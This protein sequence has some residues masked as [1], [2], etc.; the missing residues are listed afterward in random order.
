[1]QEGREREGAKITIT[2]IFFFIRGGIY[3]GNR[4]GFR[5]EL[6]QSAAGK[7]ESRKEQAYLRT[8]GPWAVCLEPSSPSGCSCYH[9]LPLSLYLV[10]WNY[11]CFDSHSEGLQRNE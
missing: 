1:L 2:R 7:D 10:Y 8:S 9:L 5:S 11:R 6:G 3:Q 4:Q